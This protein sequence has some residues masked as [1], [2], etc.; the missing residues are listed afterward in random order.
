MASGGD[1]VFFEGIKSL[2]SAEAA[3]IKE[4]LIVEIVNSPKFIF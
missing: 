1:R 4:L 2:L 3:Y